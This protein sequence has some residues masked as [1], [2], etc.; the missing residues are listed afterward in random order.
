MQRSS[1]APKQ[2]ADHALIRGT[3]RAQQLQRIMQVLMLPARATR[4]PI[5]NLDMQPGHPTR[6]PQ[7]AR[8]ITGPDSIA[9]ELIEEDADQRGALEG[10]EETCELRG[11]PAT[12]R[13]G[14]AQRVQDGCHFLAKDKAQLEAPA[15]RRSP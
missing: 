14:L 10:V 8:T 1:A 12:C 3:K 6:L 9:L 2:A 4:W 7:P 13:F 15:A 11:C 5:Y